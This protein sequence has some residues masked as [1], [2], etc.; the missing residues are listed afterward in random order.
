M[1]RQKFKLLFENALLQAIGNAEQQ[2]GR[3]IPD[4]I[5]IELHGAN[6]RGDVLDVPSAT[7][8]LYLGEDLFYR[9]VDIAVI[10]VGNSRTKIF[11]RASAHRP[12]SF[13]QAWNDPPGMGPFKQ[14]LSQEIVVM[15][16]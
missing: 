14:L 5:E 8:A 2:L 3:R 9:V 13:D 12:G 4:A 7:D 1:D 16:G 6:H 11:V 10:E 15:N